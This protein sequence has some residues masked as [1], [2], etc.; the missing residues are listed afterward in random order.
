M[1]GLLG[2]TCRAALLLYSVATLI[3]V[4]QLSPLGAGHSATRRRCVTHMHGP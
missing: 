4:D 2:A 3:V 1:L